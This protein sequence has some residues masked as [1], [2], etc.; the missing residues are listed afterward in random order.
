MTLRELY[1]LIG[2]DYEQATR[3]LRMDKLIDKH[4]RKLSKNGVVDE[5]IAAGQE[6]DPTR[7]FEASHAM[8]G[9]CANLGLIGL[10]DAASAIAEE[11][12]PGNSRTLTDE[13]VR[14]KIQEIADLYA[15]TVEGIRQYEE[16]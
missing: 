10:A 3:V 9:I 14:E 6:M 11:Y 16:A 1:E 13:Q 12:R 4:I 2:G 8:K 5:V 15:R 7:L